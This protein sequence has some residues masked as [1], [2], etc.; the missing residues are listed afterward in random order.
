MNNTQTYELQ[1]PLHEVP[2]V[3]VQTGYYNQAGR[4]VGLK[5]EFCDGHTACL[6]YAEIER[7]QQAIRPP[8]DAQTAEITIERRG[9]DY[10]MTLIRAG[11]EVVTN[12]R[13]GRERA[14]EIITEHIDKDLPDLDPT[15]PATW[16][17]SKTV[18][19]EG[20]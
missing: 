14:L 19:A 5:L 13:I 17:W 3:A 18:L 8:A 4:A 20:V 6:T 16:T 10:T 12:H 11:V 9:F 1:H 15:R 2:S 7:L